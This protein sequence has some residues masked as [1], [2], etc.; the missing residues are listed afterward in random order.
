M[1]GCVAGPPSGHASF[2]PRPA[3][4][5]A[6]A[7]LPLEKGKEKAKGAIPDSSRWTCFMSFFILITVPRGV[8]APVLQVG[9]L[10]SQEVKFGA[11]GNMEE[12]R[13]NSSPCSPAIRLCP[14]TPAPLSTGSFSPGSYFL[15][16]EVAAATLLIPTVCTRLT[17]DH[18]QPEFERNQGR[19]G[20][21]SSSSQ[22]VSRAFDLVWVIDS[23]TTEVTVLILLH[24]LVCLLVHFSVI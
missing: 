7:Q 15:R 24:Y 14:D 22:F 21:L 1:P 3:L 9:R 10:R 17:G 8:V 12:Q 11:Q 23:Q 5:Q 6:R 13:P 20:H 19:P 4:R 2:N 18:W 16:T